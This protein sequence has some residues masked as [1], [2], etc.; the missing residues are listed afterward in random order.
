MK[1][2][3]SNIFLESCALWVFEKILDVTILQVLSSNTAAQICCVSRCFKNLGHSIQG[4]ESWPE[5]NSAMLGVEPYQFELTYPPG[6]EPALHGE[7]EERSASPEPV[8]IGNT[9]WC[10]C[11]KCIS[12]MSE[13]CY[14]TFWVRWSLILQVCIQIILCS[15]V[16]LLRAVWKINLPSLCLLTEIN[17]TEH[18][19]F[20]I[21]CVL[22]RRWP[23]QED[24]GHRTWLYCSLA[25]DF[26]PL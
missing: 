26:V 1:S 3:F 7:G 18:P 15:K 4:R 2:R 13:D 19:K 12:M 17:C 20:N 24:S 10:V 6:E 25:L 9:D 8:G 14:W 23:M 22:T 16:E 21:Q 11:R 5:I